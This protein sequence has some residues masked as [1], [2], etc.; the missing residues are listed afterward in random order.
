VVTECC[1]NKHRYPTLGTHTLTITVDRWA[2][3]EEAFKK[4]LIQ[5]EQKEELYNTLLIQKDAKVYDAQSPDLALFKRFILQPMLELH[6][7]ELNSDNSLFRGQDR[8]VREYKEAFEE[9]ESE[10][11][12]AVRKA[13]EEERSKIKD[14]TEAVQIFIAKV[15]EENDALQDKVSFHC[16]IIWC[17]SACELEL[18]ASHP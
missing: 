10:R 15:L 3:Q 11:G 8:E 16:L 2:T 4:R 18:G 1:N 12:D 7:H 5:L 14:E 9:L 6:E 17:T 13:Q